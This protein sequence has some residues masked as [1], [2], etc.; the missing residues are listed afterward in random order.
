MSSDSFV[1]L[2]PFKGSSMAGCGGSVFALL[3]PGGSLRQTSPSL[4][5]V[6]EKRTLLKWP[7]WSS[8]Y[9]TWT[10]GSKSG[11]SSCSEKPYGQESAPL[12]FSQVPV[13]IDGTI[14]INPVPRL[15]RTW[16]LLATLHLLCSVVLMSVILHPEPRF[17]FSFTH[18]LPFAPQWN[19]APHPL[20]WC[21][22]DDFCA[23]DP[24]KHFHSWQGNDG[25]DKY[26][27]CY[28]VPRSWMHSAWM[29]LLFV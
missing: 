22:Q 20:A 28:G 23:M 21:A 26:G 16:H 1:T 19:L 17:T 3:I 5:T 9:S 29:T 10:S 7:K 15:S 27:S 24:P 14:R 6:W 11:F 12:Q 2:L 25:L 18:Y 13:S 8:R 4:S